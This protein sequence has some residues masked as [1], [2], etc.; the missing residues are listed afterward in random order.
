MTAARQRNKLSKHAFAILVADR[1]WDKDEARQR[2]YK[3]ITTADQDNTGSHAT[4]VYMKTWRVKKMTEKA[5]G[6]VPRL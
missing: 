3:A 6:K 1:S 4:L 2:C 5:R